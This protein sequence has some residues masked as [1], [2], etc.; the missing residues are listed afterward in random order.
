MHQ[1]YSTE[2]KDM[3]L[4][5]VVLQLESKE[6]LESAMRNLP[7]LEK[8]ILL[9]ASSLY[10][11]RKLLEMKGLSIDDKT[12]VV[13]EMIVALV[14]RFPKVFDYD[15][16]T[17]MQRF[18]VSIKA[19]FKADRQPSDIAR[20]IFTLYR[21]RKELEQRE[22]GKR[23]LLLRLKETTLHTPF[24]IKGVLSV[25]VGLN[26]LNEHELFEKR[27]LLSALS[28]FISHPEA[29]PG[30]YY[31]DDQVLY[32]EIEKPAH[33]V[34]KQRLA[35]EILKRIEQLVPP[36]FMPRNEEEVMR[37]ILILSNELRYLRD[38]P[39]MIIS[40]DEQAGSELSFT[41][42][43]AR[44]FHPDSRP[45]EQLLEGHRIER[46][47][48]VGKLR[49]KVPKE[50]VV[51]RIRLASDQFLREDYSVDLF[52]ARQHLVHTIEQ[53]FGQVRD[54][55]GGMI[56]KQSENF[57]RLKKLLGR[58]AKKHGLLLQN[59][60][61]SIFPVHL[62]TTLDA[63]LLKILFSM[64]V[65]SLPKEGEQVKS[66]FANDHL[67]VMLKSQDP[68]I[69]ETIFNAVPS[70]Q[71]LTVHM[72]VFNSHYLGLIHLN[73]DR[74]SQERFGAMLSKHFDKVA[75]FSA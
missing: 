15:I 34:A 12:A 60:F 29:I 31:K 38:I 2:F 52:A 69:K 71:I 54:Y 72:H 10:H 25:Y 43:L 32:L 4:S 33:Q 44:L 19:G 20:I 13:H 16:F 26:F 9:G 23:H 46:V 11:A 27:H 51:A 65:E 17:E 58:G 50:A 41:V 42:I 64:L 47:K 74:E 53:I 59:F 55:N 45:I 22:E 73:N 62:S 57:D 68:S 56:A 28:N 8:E 18:L 1:I 21:F 30:S 39:Q 14:R 40:F 63:H 66:K 3:T 49:R 48:V 36:I 75:S 61:H 5:Q 67:F 70:N 35:V 6:D 24:G 37:N 7:F